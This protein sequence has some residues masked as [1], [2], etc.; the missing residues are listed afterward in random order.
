[1]AD[2]PED[3]IT[4][5]NDIIV[6]PL[7][8]NTDDKQGPF[9]PRMCTVSHCHAILTGDYKYRR[10]EQ[11]R[12]QN[13]H[14]S[15]LK[16]IREK[17]MKAQAAA[18]IPEAGL[19]PTDDTFRMWEPGGESLRRKDD[20]TEQLFINTPIEPRSRGTTEV[21]KGH[22]NI[23]DLC[24]FICT[25]SR[26]LIIRFLVGERVTHALSRSVTTFSIPGYLG[27][28]AIRAANMIGRI[29]GIRNCVKKIDYPHSVSGVNTA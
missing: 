25:L 2:S 11:H 18:L 27:K 24:Y 12:I 26:R 7:L 5:Q 8:T 23:E 19:E 16:R 22:L 10:C 17:D 9:P 14:H 20:E 15:K 1:M 13:R 4:W 6:P 21:R 3:W 29:G 28:C